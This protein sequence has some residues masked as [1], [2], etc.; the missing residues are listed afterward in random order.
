[1]ACLN[2]LRNPLLCQILSKPSGALEEAGGGGGG[3]EEVVKPA[4]R[5]NEQRVFEF[6][7]M[8]LSAIMGLQQL[9]VRFDL[10]CT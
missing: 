7:V 8:S 5:C 1:M 6:K 3:E 4:A 2:T 9:L 10:H